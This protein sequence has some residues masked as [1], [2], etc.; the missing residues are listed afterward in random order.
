MKF[1]YIEYNARRAARGAEAVRMEVTYGNETELLWMS[2]RDI[3]R[4]MM[5]FGR[6][7]E[8]RKAYRA[9]SGQQEDAND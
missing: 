4:N 1:K 7:D 9:A 3:S 8:L 2:K 5:A 6:C